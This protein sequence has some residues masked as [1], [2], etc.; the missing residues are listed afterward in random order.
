[1]PARPPTT[2]IGEWRAGT[3]VFG[4]ALLTQKEV[5][6][7]RNGNTYLDL[8]LS[9]ATGWIVAKVWP[10]SP[11]LDGE[12]EETDFV[13]VR[14]EVKLYRDQLQASL[15]ECRRARPE[16]HERGFDP[17][18]LVPS[19]PKSID[20]LWAR[21]EEILDERLER[22]EARQL[23]KETLVTHGEALREHPAARRIHHAYRG[24][25]LEHTVAMAELAL[26]VAA[27]YDEIDL[28]L[29]LLGVLFHDL[30]KL[31]ELGRMPRNDYTPHGSLVGHVVMGRDLLLECCRAVPGFPEDL[32]LALEH[33]VLAH[34]GRLEFGSPVA[35]MTAEAMALHAIDDLDS[36]LAQLRPLRGRGPAFQ[37]L[38][39]L[40]R[41]VYLGEEDQESPSR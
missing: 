29:L 20:R 8:V 33:L 5:R 16:D 18:L 7:D 24:G 17:S 26:A 32:R 3:S 34:Q 23:A 6:Q 21:L 37:Y 35:P 40:G 41:S 11:A 4:F 14:G 9:D 25:L 22:P 27:L 30:G 12:Y 10:D 13:A 2:P 36:K 38:R 28:D 31:R 19:T 1:M 39:S 15:H